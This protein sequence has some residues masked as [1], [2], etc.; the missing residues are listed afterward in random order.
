MS[1]TPS[2]KEAW[3]TLTVFNNLVMELFLDRMKPIKHAEM[4]AKSSL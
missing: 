3:S 1:S 2:F 4:E